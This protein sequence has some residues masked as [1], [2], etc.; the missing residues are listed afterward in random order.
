MGY[1]S[2]DIGHKIFSFALVGRAHN[3]FWL[4]HEGVPDP[5]ELHTGKYIAP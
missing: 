1:P 4:Q 3:L 5:V 2:P